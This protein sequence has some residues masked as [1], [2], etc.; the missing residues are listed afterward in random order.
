MN[1][2]VSAIILVAAIFMAVWDA[3]QKGIAKD[4]QRIAQARASAFAVASANVSQ[5]ARA[6]AAM[7][8]PVHTSTTTL[9][10]ASES[11]QCIPLPSRLAVG[12]WQVVDDT[13]HRTEVTIHSQPQT[14]AENNFCIV[15]GENGRR[16]CFVRVPEQQTA[17]LPETSSQQ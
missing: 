5:T 16:W 9:T 11:D 15:T 2:R 13:G 10:V 17:E 4:R 1:V 8:P 3:D 12:T 14:T 7:A 6:T